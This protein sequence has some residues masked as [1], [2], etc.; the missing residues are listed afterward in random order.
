MSKFVVYSPSLKL[1]CRTLYHTSA[2][3]GEARQFDTLDLALRQ[4]RLKVG[5]WLQNVG[6]KLTDDWIVL[7][8]VTSYALIHD[9][10]DIKAQ[11]LNEGLPSDL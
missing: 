11:A 4:A 7:E 6:V 5:Q 8:V 10:P 9:L 1:Y 2:I 3:A